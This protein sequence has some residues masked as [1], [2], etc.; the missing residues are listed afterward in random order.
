MKHIVSFS[1]GLS[2][3]ITVE[4]VLARYGEKD[5][6]IVFM[7]TPLRMTTITVLWMVP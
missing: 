7:D 6:E 3:A 5:T 1:T 4:R 2:S